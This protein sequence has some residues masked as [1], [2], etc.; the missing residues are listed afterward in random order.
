VSLPL[1]YIPQTCDEWCWAAG[2]TMVATYFGISTSQCELASAY[3]SFNYNCCFSGACSYSECNHGAGTSES[4]DR[5]FQYVGIHGNATT[6]TGSTVA[7]RQEMIASELRARRPVLLAFMGPYLSHV[8]L[9]TG[10]KIVGTTRVFH[11][12]DPLVGEVDR[13]FNVLMNGGPDGNSIVT[14]AWWNFHR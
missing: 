10:Y 3:S 8:A 5:A 7:I 12:M 13:P 2:V 9:V 1:T 14:D 6:I 4:V 11:V